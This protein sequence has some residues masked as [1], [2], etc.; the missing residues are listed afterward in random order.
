MDIA[1]MR[2]TNKKARFNYEIGE[3]VEA[4]IKLTGA[5][6]KSVKLGQ[7]DMSNAYVKIQ[8]G[9]NLINLNIFPYKYADNTNYNPTRTRGLL[10]KEDEITSLKSKMK[11]ARMLLVPTAMYTRRGRVK[12]ELGL[13]RGKKKYEKRETIKKRDM[14]REEKTL[15]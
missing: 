14:E 9:L 7:A 6:V 8:N 2:I 5:E 13:A 12:I 3:R 10:L 4:G 15:K 11:Q 1:D